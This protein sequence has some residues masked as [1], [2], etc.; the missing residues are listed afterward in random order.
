MTARKAIPANAPKPRDRKPK[1]S[2]EARQAEA[3]GYAAIELNCGVTLQIPLGENMPLEVIEVLDSPVPQSKDKKE[4]DAAERRH[5]M[6]V[7]KALLGP[8][9]WAAFRAARPTVRDY[10]ELGEKISALTGN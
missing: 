9:Q 8:E 5:E 10:T 1:K 7:C 2:A 6:A 3:D 4:R